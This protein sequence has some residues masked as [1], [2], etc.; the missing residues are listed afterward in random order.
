[1]NT[2]KYI[3]SYRCKLCGGK[4]CE[5]YV[6]GL[7]KKLG[8]NILEIKKRLDLMETDTFKC[9]E[10]DRMIYLRFN[11]PCKALDPKTKMC[12]IYNQ[13]ERPTICAEFP[14]KDGKFCEFAKPQ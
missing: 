6:L 4:C 11:I 13:P 9:E 12:S 8:K 10:D 5:F 3:D 14:Y 2:S 7:D 1:M